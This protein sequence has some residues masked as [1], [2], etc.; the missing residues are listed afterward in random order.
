M[1]TEL[2]ELSTANQQKN[3]NAFHRFLPVAFPV[4]KM[5]DRDGVAHRPGGRS[6]TTKAIIFGDFVPVKRN[7]LWVASVPLH[8]AQTLVT[9]RA[10]ARTGS[11]HPL[12]PWR[13][14]SYPG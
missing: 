1:I 10:L 11:T 12:R 4:R 7:V 9:A 8:F 3:G 14:A 6:A 13:C 2:R 5:L